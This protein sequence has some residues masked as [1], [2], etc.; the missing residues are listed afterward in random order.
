M[1]KRKSFL[2]SNVLYTLIAIIIGF[3]IGAKTTASLWNN[4]INGANPSFNPCHIPLKN[5][6]IGFQYL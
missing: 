3:I 2:E 1:K 5:P 4:G 6:E